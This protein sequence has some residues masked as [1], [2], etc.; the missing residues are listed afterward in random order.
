MNVPFRTEGR[1]TVPRLAAAHVSPSQS[2]QT[3]NEQ[4]IPKQERPSEDVIT[5]MTSEEG[6][7]ATG[8][9]ENAAFSASQIV[10]G[11]PRATGIRSDIEP[12]SPLY[13][14]GQRY[15]AAMPQPT[16]SR[17]PSSAGGSTPIPTP[18]PTHQRLISSDVF[19]SDPKNLEFSLR[20]ELGAMIRR[21]D[22]PWRG[23]VEQ[24]HE[25][26]LGLAEHG[27][28]GVVAATVTATAI[29][30]YVPTNLL[31]L[32][33]TKKLEELAQLGKVVKGP[34]NVTRIEVRDPAHV[35]NVQQA[36]KEHGKPVAL[37][38][39]P[40]PVIVEQPGTKGNWNPRLMKDFKPNT[41]YQVNGYNY[42]IDAM[43][44]VETI[45]GRIKVQKMHRHDYA[46]QKM[47][48]S[49]LPNDQGG[50]IIATTLGGPG[51]NINMFPQNG[52]FNMG[53]YRHK[54][55]DMWR[56]LTRAGHQVDVKIEFFYPQNST[57]HRP[58][59]MN[60][61]YTVDGGRARQ[62]RYRNAPG[63]Q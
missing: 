23:H 48:H 42:D 27:P 24:A 44:R 52:N 18:Q 55:E 58:D 38:K 37:P 49:G 6:T 59:S 50:H 17:P 47:G 5:P 9:Y 32:I 28:L 21:M 34:N 19:L 41:T 20:K 2:S 12:V 3:A 40:R 22:L 10:F 7:A 16:P 43:G 39:A 13:I 31:D 33:P 30:F 62:E 26:A 11:Q 36:I 8:T 14:D 4:K 56:D 63:G 57:S 29:D 61:T 25:M 35:A 15:A 54:L 1:L 46:Q 51:E 60:I 45:S 53:V